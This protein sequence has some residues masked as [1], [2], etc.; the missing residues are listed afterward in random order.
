ME[1]SKHKHSFKFKRFNK[2][3]YM[4]RF[5]PTESI[6]L[7]KLHFTFEYTVTLPILE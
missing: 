3:N 6:R 4:E 1:V 2:N 7:K 5:D